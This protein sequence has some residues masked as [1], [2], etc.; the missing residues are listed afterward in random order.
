MSKGLPGNQ[1]ELGRFQQLFG[2]TIGHYIRAGIQG[3]GIEMFGH[4]D[5]GDTGRLRNDWETSFGTPYSNL[6]TPWKNIIARS[7]R[8]IDNNPHAAAM[9]NTL[10]SH[11]IGR[12][13]RPTPRVKN[14]DGK[15]VTGVNDALEEGWQRYNDE[16][17][18]TGQE[19]FL[20]MQNTAFAQIVADGGILSNMVAAPEGSFLS[21]QFQMLSVLRLDLTK[22]GDNPGFS[23]DPRVK[24]TAFGT[25]LD[26][27]GMPVSYWIQGIDK[28]IPAEKMKLHF[29]KTKAEQFVAPPWLTPALQ[30]LWYNSKLIEDKLIACRIQAMIGLFVPSS[31]FSSLL[32]QQSASTTD[33]EN[34]TQIKMEPGRIYHGAKGEEPTVIQADDSIKDVLT[35]LQ[36]LLLR[37]VTMTQGVSYATVTRDLGKVNMASGRINVNDDRRAYRMLQKWFAKNYCQWYWNSFVDRMFLEGKMPA[38]QV[39][40]YVNNPWK[41]QQAQW[42]P[43]G[44]GLIDPSRE[45]AAAV[46][47]HGDQMLTLD[48]WY[49]EQGRDWQEELEQLSEEQK[50]LKKLGLEKPVPIMGAGPNGNGNGNGRVR[51][52]DRVREDD[53]ARTREEERE[54]DR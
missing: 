51:N 17:D 12:G 35:P 2:N 41:Y 45:A 33:T 40:A 19:T 44:F 38:D 8:L 1:Y 48:Q 3:N 39:V 22:D 24:K 31:M 7:Q 20:E 46:E 11:V 27:N 52:R 30:Y 4:Y 13:L 29:R 5:S 54:N 32:D 23:D 26:G 37:A 9:V 42:R 28:P 14:K 18:A 50:L 43:E 15:P 36:E 49:S 21:V 47:L 53:R 34:P 16:L 25:N 6:Y 10:T